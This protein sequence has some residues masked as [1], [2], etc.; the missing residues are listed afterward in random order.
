FG[1]KQSGD[2]QTLADL[3]KQYGF[4][5]DI[6]PSVQFRGRAVSSS[7]IR[8]LLGAGN[9]SMAARLLDRP[10]A[11]EGTVVKGH[12]IGSKQ[13]VPTLNLATD[14]E[15]LPANGVYITRTFES[16]GKKRER[17]WP[18]ITNIGTRPTFD[19]DQLTIET[20]LLAP[21]ESET[22]SAIRVEFLR[23]VREERKFESAEA[24]KAQIVRDVGRAQEYFRR[25]ADLQTA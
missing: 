21:L 3:G 1:S 4:T 7:E 10:Y 18:S 12:G 22:P 11:L 13:T 2:T 8:R 14:A 5:T 16:T 19:G 6:A 25:T 9:V 24:L 20:F 15:V 17:E 23:R